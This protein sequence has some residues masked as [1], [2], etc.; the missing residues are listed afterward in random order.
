MT[1]DLGPDECMGFPANLREP[2]LRFD[3][4]VFETIWTDFKINNLGR[5]QFHEGFGV[6]SQGM[7]VIV[8]DTT[9]MND[10]SHV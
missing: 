8:V 3:V 5:C 4:E 10:P 1:D 6:G 7:I 9:I 2:S